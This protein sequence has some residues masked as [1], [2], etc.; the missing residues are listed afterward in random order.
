MSSAV[1]PL[2]QRHA[3]LT[4][5]SIVAAAVDLLTEAPFD[6]LSAKAIAKRAGMSERT[7]FRHFAG[8][9]ELLDGVAA[10]MIARIA[11]PPL[12]DTPEALLDYPRALFTRF[13]QVAE[14]ARAAL[15]SELYG[16]VGRGSRAGRAKAIDAL[17]DAHAA[18][19]SATDRRRASAN[20]QYQL[21]ASTWHYYRTQLDQPL[22][23]A[24]A[25]ARLAV[26]QFLAG[27]GITP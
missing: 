12:P 18:G 2:H 11:A 15:H 22:A 21:T 8:R 10:E 14:L 23:E 7:V 16:R 13:E 27:L 9:D 25:C 5:E 20:L 17:I 19:R 24:I 3:D 1:L 26:G 4:R 6:A